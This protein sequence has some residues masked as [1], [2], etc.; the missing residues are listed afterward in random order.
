MAASTLTEARIRAFRPR[1]S[2][3]DIRDARLK[4]FG[5]R[6]YPTGCKRYFIH[7]QHQGER[8]WKIIG[9]CS[10]ISLID[11]RERAQA[12]IVA[13]RNGTPASPGE[14]PFETVA[15]EVFHRYGRR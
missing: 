12:L 3:Y 1:K 10:E 11:A 13:T 4:G 7:T 2:A 6:V 8:I 9:A 14:T 5:I 15:E